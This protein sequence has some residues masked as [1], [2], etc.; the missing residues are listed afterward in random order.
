M[1]EKVKEFGIIRKLYVT[2]IDYNL[3]LKLTFRTYFDETWSK[4]GGQKMGQ[5]FCAME[6]YKF[7]SK[8]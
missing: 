8:I 3:L 6:C 4:M 5:I 2:F 7:S 1:N